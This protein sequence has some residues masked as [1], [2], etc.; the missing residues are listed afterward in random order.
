MKLTTVGPRPSLPP[1][2]LAAGG[3]WDDRPWTNKQHVASRLANLTEVL[4]VEPPLQYSTAWRGGKWRGWSP[5][6]RR[7]G[8]KSLYTFRPVSP[9]PCGSHLATSRTLNSLANSLAVRN[10]A[11]HLGFSRPVLWIYMPTEEH[12]VGRL[13]ERLA[14]YHCVDD[15]PAQA[16]LVGQESI[17][18]RAEK[19]LLEKTD[20]VVVTSPTLLDRRPRSGEIHLLPN[21]ADIGLFSKALDVLPM[22]AG[23]TGLQG[24]LVGYWG[25]LDR[26]KVDFDLVAAVAD[27]LPRVTFVMIGNVGMVD[28]TAPSSLPVRRNLVYLSARSQSDLPSYARCFTVLLIPY[29]H[30]RYTDSVF[31]LKVYE[32]LATGKPV[33]ST[34]LPSIQSLSSVI[35]FADG[36]GA[37]AA[38][39]ERAIIEDSMELRQRRCEEARLNSWEHRVESIVRILLEHPKMRGAG[40]SSAIRSNAHRN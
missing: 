5:H 38:A 22:P 15:F 21:V 29:V 4:F 3:F 28:R 27:A 32:Y 10:A 36:A 14:I 25:A 23:L 2:I 12:Y 20:V 6:P 19:R 24:P 8:D 35:A 34:R 13:G 7:I 33:V 9:F 1:V 40:G 11:R 26:Y 31:P 16:A 30:N 18:Q 39:I 37:F 17:A